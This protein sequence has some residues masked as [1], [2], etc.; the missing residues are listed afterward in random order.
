[1]VERF[2]RVTIEVPGLDGAVDEYTQLF[3]AAPAMLS[4]DADKRAWWGLSNTVI[5]L[6]QVEAGSARVGALVLDRGASQQ[7]EQVHD[8]PL[9]LGLLA[10]DGQGTA[11]FRA[12]HPGA[13]CPQLSVDHVVLRTDDADACVELFAN[14]LGIRLALD[15]TVPQWGGRMLFFRTGKMTLEVIESEADGSAGNYFWGIAY[16]CPDIDRTVTAMSGRGVQLSEIRDG[17]KP[18]TRVAT[19]KSHCLGIPTLLIEPAKRD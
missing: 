5:E 4:S 14:E 15:K 6:L 2:D 17:R 12:D 9:G 16:Q 7:S 13:Q 1:M 10:S 3:G 18:G 8:N 11:A 19:V